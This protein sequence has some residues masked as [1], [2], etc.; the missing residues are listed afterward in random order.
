[1]SDFLKIVGGIAVVIVGLGVLGCIAALA[2][3][4]YEERM[5]K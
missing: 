4:R 5:K 1:M 3:F 2:Q